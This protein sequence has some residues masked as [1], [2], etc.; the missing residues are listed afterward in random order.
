MYAAKKVT[1]EHYSGNEASH[2][3]S[4]LHR[5]CGLILRIVSYSAKN[6]YKGN[7]YV[8]KKKPSRTLF[9]ELGL[10]FEITLHRLCRKLSLFTNLE[11]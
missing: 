9:W 7:M 5:L 10:K 11:F 4:P 2:L 8:G 3:Y 1:P 6:K